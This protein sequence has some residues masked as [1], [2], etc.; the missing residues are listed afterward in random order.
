MN[1]GPVTLRLGAGEAKAL[2]EAA[3][4]ADGTHAAGS[5]QINYR[6]AMKKLQAARFPHNDKRSR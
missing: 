4:L 3:L 1:I 5:A 6:N 2:Y